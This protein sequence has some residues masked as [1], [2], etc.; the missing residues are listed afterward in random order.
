MTDEADTTAH[1]RGRED[2]E[3]VKER[4]KQAVAK[5]VDGTGLRVQE[6]PHELVITNPDDP[7]KGQLHVDFEHGYM[8]WERVVWDFWGTVTE[9]LGE[10]GTKVV[11]R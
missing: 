4:I 7:E 10:E 5:L 11:T 2:R 3:Q 8:S 1:E 9:G 6:L